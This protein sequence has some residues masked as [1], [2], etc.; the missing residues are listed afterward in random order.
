M[1]FCLIPAV[2][3]LFLFLVSVSTLVMYKHLERDLLIFIRL[4]CYIIVF[5]YDVFSCKFD[6]LTQC[7]QIKL[8]AAISYLIYISYV[9]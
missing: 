8:T 6:L 2:E 1:S 5:S 4:C 3:H 7:I 9:V